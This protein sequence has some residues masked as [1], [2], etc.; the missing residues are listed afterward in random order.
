VR[1]QAIGALQ[2]SDALTLPGPA[3]YTYAILS[4]DTYLKIKMYLVKM[5]TVTKFLLQIDLASKFLQIVVSI[6]EFL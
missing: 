5:V 3:Q 4:V 6:C 2:D 1:A